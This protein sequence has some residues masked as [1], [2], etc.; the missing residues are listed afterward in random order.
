MKTLKVLSVVLALV[1]VLPLA[2]QELKVDVEKSKLEWVGKKVTG[3]HNGHINLKSGSLTLKDG[4]IAGGEFLIDMITMTCEDLKDPKW[5]KKLM[6]HLKSDD[7]FGVEDHPTSKLEIKSASA[8]V[9]GKAEVKAHLT[10]KGKTHPITFTAEKSGMGFSAFITVDR[11][12]YDVRYGSG[13]FFDNLGDKTIY[14]DFTLDV[15]LVT[16]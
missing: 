12:K 8:F 3:Q 15:S 4:N 11:T 1:F 10:V 9:D 6:D 14:D 13:K 2:A 7:F 5:N 16:M